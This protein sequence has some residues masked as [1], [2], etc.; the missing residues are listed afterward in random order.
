MLH[1]TIV[2]WLEQADPALW[3]MAVLAHAMYLYN[4]VPWPE[5]GICLADMLTHTQ[6]EQHKFHDCHM[7]DCPVYM[8]DKHLSKGKKLPQWKPH[9]KHIIYIG[10]S[11]M[12]ASMVPL[13][14][15]PNTSA[16]SSV[17]HVVFDDW[18]TT[19]PLLE[20]HEFSTKLWEKLFGESC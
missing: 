13:I 3:P 20:N 15:N 5:L 6:W 2:H 4:H 8:L 9:S 1:A 10:H 14:L 17:F 11:P 12:H 18:F 19:I 7:W 16:L